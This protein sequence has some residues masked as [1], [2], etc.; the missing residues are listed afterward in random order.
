VI[1]YSRPDCH[2]CHEAEEAIRHSSCSPEV[3]IEMV[4][5]DEDPRLQELYKDDVPVVFINGV[6]VFKHRV[7]PEDFCRKVRRLAKRL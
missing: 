1:I 4:N 2:L 7:S 6:K 5:I 3:E